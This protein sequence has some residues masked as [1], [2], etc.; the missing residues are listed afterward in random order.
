MDFLDLVN[1]RLDHIQAY[2][3][4]QHYLDHPGMA[5]RWVQNWGSQACSDITQEMIEQFALKRAK[6]SA[7]VANKE[8]KSL[9]ATF[10]FGKKKKWIAPISRSEL[11]RGFWGTRTVRQ[12]RSI[13]LEHI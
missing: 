11:S 1:R 7:Y 10:R 3:S 5:K 12:L 4:E 6:V 9:R 13:V 2:F 8:I